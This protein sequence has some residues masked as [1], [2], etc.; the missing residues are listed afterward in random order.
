MRSTKNKGSAQ[1]TRGTQPVGVLRFLF[2]FLQA[3]EVFFF[4]LF[5]FR[6]LFTVT[7][8]LR[9]FHVVESQKGGTSPR[10]RF[11]GSPSFSFF[12]FLCVQGVVAC[13]LNPLSDSSFFLVCVCVF[14]SCLMDPKVQ[15][16][17]L[18]MCA[19]MHMTNQPTT[20]GKVFS[21]SFSFDSFKLDRHWSRIYLKE[22]S[23]RPKNVIFFCPL[24]RKKPSSFCSLPPS[25][26]SCVCARNYRELYT[27]MQRKSCNIA[28][29][30]PTFFC[31]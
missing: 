22:P 27:R 20:R 12:Q 15:S 19:N 18:F 17:E 28:R 10:S 1:Q 30:T 11:L 31:L 5:F 6:D 7:R 13:R 21:F 24:V 8:R 23:R 3:E 29:A 26:F 14:V 4:F 2:F 25:L 9:F 16:V